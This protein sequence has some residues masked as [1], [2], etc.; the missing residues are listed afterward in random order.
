MAAIV[1]VLDT[2][3]L[4]PSLSNFHLLLIIKIGIAQTLSSNDSKESHLFFITT[5]C[6]LQPNKE[7]SLQILY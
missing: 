2:S 7:E 3:S 5:K 4:H 1:P 6:V